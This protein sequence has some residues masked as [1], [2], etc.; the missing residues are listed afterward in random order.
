MVKWSKFIK[1]SRY[2]GNTIPLEATHDTLG[3][4][5]RGIAYTLSSEPAGPGPYPAVT[6][7]RKHTFHCNCLF[8]LLLSRSWPLQLKLSSATPT[9]CCLKGNRHECQRTGWA[10]SYGFAKTRIPL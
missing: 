4:A 8:A 3:V 9:L 7:S 1:P 10:G 6:D 2:S 5:S